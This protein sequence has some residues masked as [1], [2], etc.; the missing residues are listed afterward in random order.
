MD[1][2]TFMG[3]VLSEHGIGPSEE[4]VKDLTNA[5][6]PRSISEVKSFLGLVNFSGR[7]IKELATKAHP[8][9]SLTKQN[10]IFEWTEK[11]EHSFQELKSSL[12]S[13]IC[14]GYFSLTAGKKH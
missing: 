6:R 2:I 1:E 5:E 14:L 10:A 8:L 9:K 12:T 3:H 7:F 11:E 4:R 13:L